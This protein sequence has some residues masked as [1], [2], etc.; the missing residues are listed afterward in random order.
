MTSART[1]CPANCRWQLCVLT[2]GTSVYPEE[3][4]SRTGADGDQSQ[5]VSLARSIRKKAPVGW[6]I[7]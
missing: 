3:V 2:I 7:W 6:L 5:V 1:P 4:Y